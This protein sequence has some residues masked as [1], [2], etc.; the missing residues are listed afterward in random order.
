MSFDK[1][2]SDIG[3]G[4][5]FSDSKKKS[6]SSSGQIPPWLKARESP[7]KKIAKEPFEMFKQAA[8]QVSPYERVGSGFASP[9]GQQPTSPSSEQYQIS[10]E[11]RLKIE[12]EARTRLEQLRQELEEER[13]K[14]EMKEKQRKMTM[15]EQ[16]KKEGGV[17]KP[18]SEIPSKHPRGWF[19]GIMGRVRRLG[20]RTEMRLPPSG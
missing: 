11:E 7:V 9:Y 16:G 14:G 19:A 13:K 10:D 3:K 5:G 12:K 15:A 8:R 4:A 20:R 6:S 18:L 1:P 2:V 17:R